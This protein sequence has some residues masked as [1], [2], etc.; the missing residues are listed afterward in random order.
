MK[1]MMDFFTLPVLGHN[2]DCSDCHRTNSCKRKMH[3]VNADSALHMGWKEKVFLVLSFF[4][5]QTKCLIHVL[6]L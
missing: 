5:F 6:Q 4:S 3:L 1:D 2:F